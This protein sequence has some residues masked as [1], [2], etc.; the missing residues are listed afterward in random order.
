MVLLPELPEPNVAAVDA[1]PA[2][3]PVVLVAP[4]GLALADVRPQRLVVRVELCNRKRGNVSYI[5]AAR[6]KL[7]M[8]ER[9]ARAK[10]SGSHGLILS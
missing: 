3:V 1:Q 5:Y 6:E 9:R 2:A 8:P 10:M 7:P 4:Q